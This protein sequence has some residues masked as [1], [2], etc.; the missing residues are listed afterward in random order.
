MMLSTLQMSF[1]FT[2]TKYLPGWY[3]E[4]CVVVFSMVTDGNDDGPERSL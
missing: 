1:S 4:A 3:S 2:F